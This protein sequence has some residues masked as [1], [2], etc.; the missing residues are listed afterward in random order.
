MTPIPAEEYQGVL[1]RI[2]KAF[3]TFCAAHDLQFLLA[4]GTALGAVRHKG[5][6][7]WDDDIDL[8]VPHGMYEKLIALAEE[9]PFIDPDRR[10]K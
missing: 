6:I 5:F 2:L 1:L 3:K 10:Y 8:Y 4:G 9:D 7:P